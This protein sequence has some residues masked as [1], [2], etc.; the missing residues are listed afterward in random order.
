MITNISCL[1]LSNHGYGFALKLSE[2]LPYSVRI[3][4]PSSLNL[5]KTI[6]YKN[7][8]DI[9]QYLYN[10]HGNVLLG[11]C[12]SA[13]IIRA[14]TSFLKQK[15]DGI[16]V[17]VMSENLQY[18]IP[19]LGAFQGANKISQEISKILS[20][21]PILT[22]TGEARFQINLHKPPK[23][24]KLLNETDA[25]CFIT[26]MLN[27][28]K[29]QLSG[30]DP[31]FLESALPFQEKANLKI[32]ICNQKPLIFEKNTLYYLKIPKIGKLTIL[33]LG[34]GAKKYLTYNAQ[35]ALLEADDIFG[36]HYYISLAEPFLPFQ[37]IYSSDNGD[38]LERAKQALNNAKKG[39]NVVLLS[40]GDPGIFAMAASVFEILDSEIKKTVKEDYQRVK[41]RIEPGI[42]AALSASAKL[43]APLGHDFVI[44]SLSNNLKSWSL[45]E[46][47]L[48]KAFEAD[49]V[50][51]IYNPISKKRYKN[52]V[53][54]LNFL[55]MHCEKERLIG[56]ATDITRQHEKYMIVSLEDLK[57]E[58]IT[59]RSTLI[60]GSSKTKKIQNLEN[61]KLKE[62]IYTPRHTNL[63]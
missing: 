9:I 12:S 63:L 37:K 45:I 54:F 18:C 44:M 32:K 53:N 15:E 46:K 26:K 23:N 41:L 36:Y 22:T 6:K 59:S 21:T 17:L 57:I 1:L 48:K 30:E 62:W 35:K 31:W 39:R 42:T 38:E 27:G 14:L 16:P 50:I 49:F 60:I 25:K 33:G 28:E 47:R 7:F 20:V 11:F 34:P 40:S 3:F 2:K 51:V 24:L 13:I 5:S 8:K 29:I 58:D 61:S 56:I 52:A 4:A 10:D 19:L 43:G 55:K